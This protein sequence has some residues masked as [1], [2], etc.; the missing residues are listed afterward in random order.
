M[1]NNKGEID[2]RQTDTYID[3]HNYYVV[4]HYLRSS[5]VWRLCERRLD[6][7]FP[8]AEQKTETE[9]ILFTYDL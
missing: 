8:A 9:K 5:C 4:L 6:P 3:R 2:N 1:M 7:G